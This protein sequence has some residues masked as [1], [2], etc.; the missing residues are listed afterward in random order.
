MLNHPLVQCFLE[1][2]EGVQQ[3]MLF[4]IEELGLVQEECLNLKRE[5]AGS[6][7]PGLTVTGPK[8][9]KERTKDIKMGNN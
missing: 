1:E 5:W 6:K 3:E 7:L 9:R 2:H 4:R 8:A